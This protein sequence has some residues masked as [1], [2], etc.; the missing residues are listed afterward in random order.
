MQSDRWKRSTEDRVFEPE[1][2]PLHGYDSSLSDSGR[3][4]LM[5]ATVGQEM[6]HH[7]NRVAQVDLATS[8]TES[9]TR[10]KSRGTY[11]LKF[12]INE[13][14]AAGIIAWAKEHLD[15]DVHA[16][17]S[18]G[19]GY[20]VNSVY[21][22]TP[23]F[24]VYH[25]TSKIQQL[26]YRLR[27]YGSEGLVWCELKRKSK[28]LVRKRRVSIEE[29]DL[30]PRLTS[31]DESDWEGNW[32]RS[33]LHAQ[34]LRP[35]CQITYQRFA[36]MR[37]TDEGTMRLTIDDHLKAQLAS[38]WEVPSNPLDGISLLDGQ[39]ILELKFQ[40][41]MPVLFRRLV[42]EQQLQLTSFSKYRTSVIKCVPLDWLSGDTIRGMDDA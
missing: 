31:N 8:A 15:A 14:R 6:T 17:P 3:L 20:R 2:N 40:G 9:P 33:Q 12:L 18:F 19:D 34:C 27:R 13:D 26:K 30:A 7:L 10:T 35:V 24:D 25:G 28:G 38:V 16:D 37:A 21:L 4:R 41:A 5:P 36:R 39:R 23:H 1:A 22:D 29:A 32:F 11:E 42:E